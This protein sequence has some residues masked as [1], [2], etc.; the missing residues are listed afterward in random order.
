[1]S[2]HEHLYSINFGYEQIECAQYQHGCNVMIDKDE[3][4]RRINEFPALKAKV[5]YAIDV[6]RNM[7]KDDIVDYIEETW[8]D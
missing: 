2:E 8:P 7:G 6:L 3:A 1:M 5:K 4:E